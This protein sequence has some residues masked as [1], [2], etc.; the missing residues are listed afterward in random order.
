MSHI[1]I[2]MIL[3]NK[4][5]IYKAVFVNLLAMISLKKIQWSVAS[6]QSLLV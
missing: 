6:T 5:H 1:F 2:L 3:R 4:E